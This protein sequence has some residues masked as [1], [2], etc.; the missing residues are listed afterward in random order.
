[1]ARSNL[2]A[3]GTS[4]ASSVQQGSS[5]QK[6]SPQAPQ[7]GIGTKLRSPVDGGPRQQ[8]SAGTV[9]AR[10]A[11]R[12]PVYGS[13]MSDRRSFR[14]DGSGSA[15]QRNSGGISRPVVTATAAVSAAAQVTFQDP[16]ESKS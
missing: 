11:E 14:P 5:Q 6:S 1:M 13:S 3:D 12:L 4:S 8:Q 7:G 2:P 10:P 15:E 9:T 16:I